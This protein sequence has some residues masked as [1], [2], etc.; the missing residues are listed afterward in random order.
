M[1]L[2]DTME[3]NPGTPGIDPATFRLAA[4]CLNHYAIPGLSKEIKMHEVSFL[5]CFER[6][7]YSKTC[8]NRTLY[9][10]EPSRSVLDRFYC[11]LN[12]ATNISYSI[13]FYKANEMQLI[14]CSLLLSAL[15][16]FRA[17]FPPIIRSSRKA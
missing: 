9:I 11:I 17:V 5:F 4:Q 12:V 16:M 7:K 6:I 1:E 15:D 8:L 14:H 10:P 2:S 13:L 3:K